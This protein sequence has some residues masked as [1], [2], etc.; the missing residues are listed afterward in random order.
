MYTYIHTYIYIHRWVYP[1]LKCSGVATSTA[2][3][4]AAPEAPVDSTEGISEIWARETSPLKPPG[5]FLRFRVRV[6]FTYG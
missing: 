3:R 4:R 6:S 1:N 5:G 2:P